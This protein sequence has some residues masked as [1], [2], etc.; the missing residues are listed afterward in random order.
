MNFYDKSMAWNV[1]KSTGSI[2]TYL[3]LKQIENIQ[4]NI[5]YEQKVN[6]NGNSKNQ[7]NNN[8]RK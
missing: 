8:S 5:G 6:T 4:K 2:D 7:G 3:E 1:F